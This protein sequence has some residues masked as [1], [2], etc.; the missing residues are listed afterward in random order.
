MNT[1]MAKGKFEKRPVQGRSG[2]V[3]HFIFLQHPAFSDTVFEKFTYLE[4]LYFL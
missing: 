3:H 2:V 4:L 1:K